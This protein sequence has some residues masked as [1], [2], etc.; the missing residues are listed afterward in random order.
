M[1][2]GWHYTEW[3][4]RSSRYVRWVDHTMAELLALQAELSS[5]HWGDHCKEIA[6]EINKRAPPIKIVEV[7][8][9]AKL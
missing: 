5:G 2:G 4:G 1:I 8:V 6:A 7:T 9:E 3:R